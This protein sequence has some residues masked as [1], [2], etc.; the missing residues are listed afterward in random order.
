MKLSVLLSTCFLSLFLCSCVTPY[1]RVG[2]SG[3][4]NDMA[5][6]ND[7]YEVT[8]QGNEFTSKEYVE[9]QLLRRCAEVTLQKG[10]QDFLILDKKT[11][12]D[13]STYTTPDRIDTSSSSS[14]N[15]SL[16]KLEK[17]T[18]TKITPGKTYVSTTYK[19][20]A[21]IKLLSDNKTDGNA[22]DANII[23]SNFSTQ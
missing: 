15:S 23:L 16:K 1:Q 17:K 4:Y 9:R 7:Q 14:F 2:F 22:F 10:Y 21:T 11:H 13:Q 3:G 6:S 20:I 12:A 19:S 8:F 5:L 18:S